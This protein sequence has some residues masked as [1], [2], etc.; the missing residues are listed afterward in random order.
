[1]LNSALFHGSSA[2]C[3]LSSVMQWDIMQM[4]PTQADTQRQ[5]DVDSW[6]E[7]SGQT[8]DVALQNTRF[9]L[10]LL[11]DDFVMHF[12]YIICIH[13]CVSAH[14]TVKWLWPISA[15]SYSSDCWHSHMTA[16]N[17]RHGP[18]HVN[19]HACGQ[20]FMFYMFTCQPQPATTR[21][22]GPNLI[23]RHCGCK[24]MNVVVKHVVSSCIWQ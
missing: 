5:A 17:W 4:S 2:A 3:Q 9:E 18:P 13:A 22:Q 20:M 23:Q 7:M 10:F 12:M 16:T 19:C 14:S 1:M 21:L 15:K 24:W 11:K 8:H 6:S